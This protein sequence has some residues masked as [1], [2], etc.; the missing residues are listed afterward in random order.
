MRPRAPGVAGYSLPPVTG[1]APGGLPNPCGPNG[2]GRGSHRCGAPG[3]SAWLCVR[4]H[5]KRGRTLVSNSSLDRSSRVRF[6]PGRRVRIS[7]TAEVPPQASTVSAPVVPAVPLAREVRADLSSPGLPTGTVVPGRRAADPRLF[8]EPSAAAR[9]S[10]GVPVL[11]SGVVWPTASRV[12]AVPGVRLGRAY[13]TPEGLPARMAAYRRNAGGPRLIWVPAPERWPAV[14]W[15][16]LAGGA[17][18]FFSVER[19]RAPGVHWHPSCSLEAGQ[20]GHTTAS[21]PAVP[22]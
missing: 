6:G 8:S 15:A 22:G 12:P 17:R 21:G 14:V 13:S 4:P 5:L 1:A 9:P 11:L 19:R 10:V 18:R 3:L 2:P 7:R 20:G 16:W